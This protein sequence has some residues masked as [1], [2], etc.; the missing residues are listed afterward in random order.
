VKD[1]NNCTTSAA[2]T[3][4]ANNTLTSSASAS[5]INCFNGNDGAITI[6]ANG[7]S[8]NYQYTWN[9]GSTSASLSNLSTGSYIVTISDGSACQKTDSVTITSPTAISIAMQSTNVLCANGNSGSATITATG[10]T[11]SYAYTWSNGDKTN[12]TSNLTSGKYKLTVNDANGCVKTDSVIITENS[13]ILLTV[14]K[15]NSSGGQNNGTASVAA[16]G[17]TLGYSYAWSNGAQTAAVTGLAPGTYTLTVKDANGCEAQ[18]SVTIESSTSI[19]DIQ[20]IHLNV[21]PNP[22]NEVVYVEL[23]D[24]IQV[25]Q[26]QLTDVIGR[27]VNV[28]TEY[29]N[30]R[31]M[32]RTASLAAAVYEISIQT[33]IGSVK[34]KLIVE[35]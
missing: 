20:N 24:N 15:T 4:G 32:I 2:I 10:G 6:T 14:S 13:A 28:E 16:S 18:S 5:N 23:P 30:H 11:P 12:T 34:Q 29:N 8:G 31:L 7:G 19:T 9:N 33:N 21:Y 22:A 26:F 25:E 3:V 27:I 35:R 1:A 17:G